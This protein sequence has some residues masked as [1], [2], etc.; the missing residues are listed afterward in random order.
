MAQAQE[1]AASKVSPVTQDPVKL[2]HLLEYLKAM[3]DSKQKVR[4]CSDNGFV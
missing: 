1:S 3:M 4:Q 2:A